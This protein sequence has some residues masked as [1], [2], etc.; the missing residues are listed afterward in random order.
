MLEDMQKTISIAQLSRNAEE[1]VKSVERDGTVYQVKR[2]GRR[3]VLIMDKQQF[4]DRLFW[5]EFELRHPNWREEMDEARRLLAE[6]KLKTLDQFLEERGLAEAAHSRKR[7]GAVRR[8]THSRRE[9][10]RKRVANPVRRS[11]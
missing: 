3:A 8:A 7:G 4:E 2:P 10:G 11:S 9:K 5:L 6:G 1:I